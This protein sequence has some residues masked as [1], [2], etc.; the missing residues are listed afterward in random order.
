MKQVV[1]K[2]LIVVLVISCKTK[3]VEK[4]FYANGNV[5]IE[6][7]VSS[8]GVLEGEYHVF[9][10]NG[11][12]KEKST[13]KNGKREGETLNYHLNGQLESKIR[14]KKDL[15]VGQVIILD[16]IGNVRSKRT[17]NSLGLIVDTATWYF[18][19]GQ[20][21]YEY[22]FQ[23]LDKE[24][25]LFLPVL[26]KPR[27]A[28]VLRYDQISGSYNYTNRLRIRKDKSDKINLTVDRLDSVYQDSLLLKT[29]VWGVKDTLIRCK[30]GGSN[31]FDLGLK[32]NDS[33]FILVIME[34]YFE[35]KKHI[36]IEYFKTAKSV[37][38]ETVKK[39]FVLE[40]LIHNMNKEFIERNN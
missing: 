13:F 21:D 1:S 5:K 30:V 7:E 39:D 34:S 36:A 23:D 33:M 27:I 10:E 35:N 6:A 17:Y 20:I 22:F 18:P 40:K 4:E 38:P 16:S 26:N 15:P 32:Y 19:S 12:I 29:T 3:S 31:C 9:F 11:T 25:T 2:L 14:Y 8:E 24:D 37:I 28:S